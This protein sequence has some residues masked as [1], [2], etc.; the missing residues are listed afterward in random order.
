MVADGVWGMALMV[1][2]TV[3]WTYQSLL[4]VQLES[5]HWVL[6]LWS[7][8]ISAFFASTPLLLYFRQSPFG[9]SALNYASKFQLLLT[10][11]LEVTIY[12]FMVLVVQ[13]GPVGTCKDRWYFEILTWGRVRALR[14]QE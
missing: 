9:G 8:F 12:V 14:M 10:P 2:M 7:F 13:L 11:I 5:V 6:F 3:C 1:M 4:V